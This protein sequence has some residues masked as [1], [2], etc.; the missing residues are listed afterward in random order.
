M[1]VYKIV[2]FSGPK[3][4]YI[5][6]KYSKRE[7]FEIRFFFVNVQFR[8]KM[9]TL[10]QKKGETHYFTFVALHVC[11]KPWVDGLYNPCFTVHF[12]PEL[13]ED[14]VVGGMKALPYIPF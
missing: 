7:Y 13:E 5:Q 12:R 10:T 2:S 4:G 8:P 9:C 14:K 6:T 1:Y 11:S 3:T